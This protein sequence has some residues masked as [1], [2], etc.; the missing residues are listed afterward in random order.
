M[1]DSDISF[2][3]SGRP[4]IEYQFS[5]LND[6]DPIGVEPETRVSL[7]RFRHPSPRQSRCEQHLAISNSSTQAAGLSLSSTQHCSQ[8]HN[9]AAA[10]TQQHR[11]HV[12]DYV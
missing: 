2:V 10:E 6:S 3:S 5:S 8:Q 7:P 4:N 9:T 12:C 1:P 11:Q